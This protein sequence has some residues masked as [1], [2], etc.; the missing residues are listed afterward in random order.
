MP[1]PFETPTPSITNL[2]SPFDPNY[3]PGGTATDGYDEDFLSIDLEEPLFEQRVQARTRTLKSGTAAFLGETAGT[4]GLG[5][6]TSVALQGKVSD[7]ANLAISSTAPIAAVG[8]T[9]ALTTAILSRSTAG[10]TEAAVKVGINA[11]GGLVGGFVTYGLDEGLDRLFHEEQMQGVGKTIYD[12]G[13]D[14]TIGGAVGG[15]VGGATIAGGTAAAAGITEGMAGVAA[16]D[17]WNPIGWGAA[18]GAAVG[19]GVTA[20]FA[21]KGKID[22][23]N[24]NKNAKLAQAAETKLV[25]N[26]H[27][28]R[29]ID[30]SML[31]KAELEAINAT[32]PEFFDR[33]QKSADQW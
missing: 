2:P 4:L 16:V 5:L 33:V 8:T 28:W 12:I 22:Q 7:E 32:D 30:K 26:Q 21:I 6:A 20:G 10:L 31:S 24:Y 23:D 11:T 14:G 19:T 13:V 3:T 15:A 29:A 9:K 17:W 1:S 18:L 25:Q 27:T